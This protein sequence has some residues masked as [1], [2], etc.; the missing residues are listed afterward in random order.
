MLR[1]LSKKTAR[2]C[3]SRYR[4]IVTHDRYFLDKVATDILA[5]EADG[6]VVFHHGDFQS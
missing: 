6:Q 2:W 5:F 3:A 1:H 4:N